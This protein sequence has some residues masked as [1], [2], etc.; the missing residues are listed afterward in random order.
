MNHHLLQAIVYSTWSGFVTKLEYKSE[1]AG[2]TIL[3][4]GKFEPSSRI[5]HVCGYPHSDPTLLNCST[6][7]TFID[8]L[9]E[10]SHNIMR[11]C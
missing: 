5:W 10:V 1:R 11:R 2:K 7:K 3:M 6:I 8:F 9:V 4:I